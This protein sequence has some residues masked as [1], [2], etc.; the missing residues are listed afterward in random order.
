MNR[1]RY[2]S[3]PCLLLEKG[4]LPIVCPVVGT[5]DISQSDLGCRLDCM[6]AGKTLFAPLMGFLPRKTL[7]RI[8]SRYDGDHRIRALP[9]SGI[10]AFWRLYN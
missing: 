3:F 6:Y 2:P 5:S 7:H 10:S 9:C 8:V 4:T 1:G